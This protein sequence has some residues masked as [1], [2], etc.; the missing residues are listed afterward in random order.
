MP[1][2]RT[3]TVLIAEPTADAK[4][5]D[6][7]RKLVEQAVISTADSTGGLLLSDRGGKMILRWSAAGVLEAER[8]FRRVRGYQEMG[9]LIAALKKHE[10]KLNGTVSDSAVAVA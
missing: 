2:E 9:K 10:A 5:N 4:R 8:G 3:A 6:D 7:C 1:S